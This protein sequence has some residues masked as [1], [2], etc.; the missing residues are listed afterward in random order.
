MKFNEFISMLYENSACSNQAR[1]VLQLFA[2]LCGENEPVKTSESDGIE[3][4]DS[5]GSPLLPKALRS[6]DETTRKR[7]FASDCSGLTAPI[8]EHIL[9]HNNIETLK[10]YLNS[11]ISQD[12]YLHLCSTLAVS[13]ENERDVIFSALFEQFIEF[14]KSPGCEPSDVISLAIE[15]IVV[16][17]NEEQNLR[18][19][20][21]VNNGTI[22]TQKN[23]RI[24]TVNGDLHI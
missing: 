10:S 19:F 17:K 24:D 9:A 15:R 6:M 7:L 5:C 2:A 12:N 3:K 21:I 20:T 22:G 11:Q 18:G 8:C 13:T 14:A 23:V 16:S 4:Y 1:Y